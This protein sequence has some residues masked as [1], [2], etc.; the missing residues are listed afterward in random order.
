MIE[1]KY[2]VLLIVLDEGSLS[3]AADKLGYTPS[4]ISRMIA[5]LE[6]DTGL[7]LLQRSKAGVTATKACSELLPIIRNIAFCCEQY[8]QT[9]S[10]I[11]GLEIGTV[12]IGT[13]Y[14]FYYRWLADIIAQ[15]H[16]IHPGIEVQLILK[17]S[18]ELTN[19][20]LSHKTDLGIVSQRNSPADWIPLCEDPLVA[21]V[22]ENS[23]YI[24]YGFV[25]AEAFSQ[26][27]YIGSY[28]EEDTD[29]ARY[30]KKHNIHVNIKYSVNDIYAAYCLVE[31]GLGITLINRLITGD[32]KGSVRVLPVRPAEWIPIGIISSP[33]Q[34]MTPAA[35]ELLDFIKKRSAADN[36]HFQDF[37]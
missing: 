4:G 15:F 30:F 25:P 32:W 34:A 28:P 29:N 27:P 3:A 18:T 11:K 35:C 23:P 12:T 16:K 24:D 36:L 17:N 20:V 37:I 22:P 33:N 19:D 10:K 8:R 13:S 26:E 14:V 6:A 1:D 7:I 5:S 21:W 2:N 9:A 31:A